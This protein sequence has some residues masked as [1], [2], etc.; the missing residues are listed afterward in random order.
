MR[1]GAVLIFIGCM[2]L[3]MPVVYF[4]KAQI[5]PPKELR[6]PY[7]IAVLTNHQV[8]YFYILG[9]KYYSIED[10]YNF[11]VF[12]YLDE[13]ICVNGTEILPNSFTKMVIDN[14]KPIELKIKT[15]N[16]GVIT[17]YV[18]NCYNQITI[19]KYNLE[20]AYHSYASAIGYIEPT[21]E[22]GYLMASM[23]ANLRLVDNVLVIENENIIYLLQFNLT[24]TGNTGTVYL[25]IAGQGVSVPCIINK[26]EIVI[27]E[28]E[29]VFRLTADVTDN[30]NRRYIISASSN[31]AVKLNVSKQFADKKFV[32]GIADGALELTSYEK[33]QPIK[34]SWIVPFN[35]LFAGTVKVTVTKT[36]AI[37]T[38]IMIGSI[39]AGAMLVVIGF[40]IERKTITGG[41]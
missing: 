22:N 36:E 8:T 35:C 33:T 16:F 21:F 41:R 29:G 38:P 31:E 23:P 3:L 11:E 5:L 19:E 30:E 15:K 20:P 2:L 40:E 7:S 39:I 32:Y 10:N 12:N 17:K 13:N 4:V 26:F 14:T 28:D 27:P 37:L 1:T 6:E 24:K 9:A 25:A 34:W 18:E